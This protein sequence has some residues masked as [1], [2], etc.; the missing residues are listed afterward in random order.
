MTHFERIQQEAKQ[1]KALGEKIGYGH[2][3]ELASALWRKHLKEKG[4]PD[5]GAFVPTLMAFIDYKEQEPVKESAK[6]YDEFVKD[7]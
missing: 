6:T 2:M 1:V 4:Y 3:M 5:T 7:I